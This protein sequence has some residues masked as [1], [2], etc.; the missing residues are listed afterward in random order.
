MFSE[1]MPDQALEASSK[2]LPAPCLSTGLSTTE[3]I[4]RKVDDA[5][6]LDSVNNAETNCFAFFNLLPAEIRFRIWLLAASVAHVV[7]A[8]VLRS[9][10]AYKNTTIHLQA[11]LKACMESR[12][13]VKQ[14]LRRNLTQRTGY[15][16]TPMLTHLCFPSIWASQYEIESWLSFRKVFERVRLVAY[17]L[18]ASFEN[19]IEHK[20]LGKIIG[21]SPLES[22]YMVT[23]YCYGG[24]N[25]EVLEMTK[26]DKPREE[27]DM[28]QIIHDE[29][30]VVEWKTVEEYIT[31]K[32]EGIFNKDKN[33]EKAIPEIRVGKLEER[34]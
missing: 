18:P 3:I 31:K 20:Q 2:D 24:Q 11:L 28:E 7:N 23:S 33:L 8:Q 12:N 21:A 30:V 16:L 32:L 25:M 15:A 1:L 26:H 10:Y 19:G 13:V 6:F 22:L 5:H 14:Q 4:N 9:S 17:P 29:T 27:F 34:D